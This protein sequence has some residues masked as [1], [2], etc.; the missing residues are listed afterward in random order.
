MK[1]LTALI[2][3]LLL[4]TSCNAQSRSSDS[5]QKL[6]T[7]DKLISEITLEIYKSKKSNGKKSSY[8][9]SLKKK[10]GKLLQVIDFEPYSWPGNCKALNYGNEESIDL[11]NDNIIV[12]SDF[13][14][15]GLKDLALMFDNTINTG[16]VYSYFLQREI[17]GF[18]ENS[19]FPLS[20]LPIEINRQERT[21]TQKNIIGCCKIKTTVFHLNQNDRWE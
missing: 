18:Y 13:N 10:S 16:T 11:H 4:S 3:F 5:G 8:Q 7:F 2:F 19:D 12:V 17:G 21:L 9:I 20:L 15:D 6:C 1:N 14:F